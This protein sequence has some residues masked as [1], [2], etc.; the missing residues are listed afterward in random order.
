MR[1]VALLARERRALRGELCGALALELRIVARVELELLRVEVHDR[2]HHGVEEV[3]VVGDQQQ[4]ARIA[5][6][7]VLEPQHGV[8]VEVVGGLVEQQQLGARHQRLR[9]VEAHAPA[10][11]K[12]RH[13]IA[14]TRIRDAESREELGRACPCG[15]AADRLEAMVQ[16]GDQVPVVRLRGLGGG[17][18]RLDLAQL[19]VAVEH[20]L[21]R[22]RGDGRRLLRDVGDAPRRRQLDVARLRCQFAAQQRE[23]RRLAAAVG[24]DHA[25]FLPGVHGQRRVLDEARGTARE[26]DVA[27]ADHDGAAQPALMPSAH[28]RSRRSAARG[29]RTGGCDRWPPRARVAAMP[30]V[31]IW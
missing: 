6:E 17:E 10:A 13:R 12:A 25:H 21:A 28:G 7:P 22:W 8:E 19:G 29:R 1:D 5:R 3:A 31:A 15:V 9:E 30:G 2:L 27:Q 11:G 24:A 26:R 4:R 14:V 16:L 18:G 23:Q 20:V